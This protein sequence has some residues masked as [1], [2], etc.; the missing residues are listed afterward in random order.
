MIDIMFKITAS[1]GFH[2]TFANG[3]TVSVQWGPGHL[4]DHYAVPTCSNLERS[5]GGVG[6]GTAEVAVYSR[7]IME[8]DYPKGYQTANEV[9]AIMN[10]VAEKH[11]K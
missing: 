8:P 1:K 6:S 3:Y 5:C 4:C 10:E 2:I 7:N 9:L 11:K